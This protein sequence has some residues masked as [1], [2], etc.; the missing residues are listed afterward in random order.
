MVRE[1]LFSADHALILPDG[2]QL[3]GTVTQVVPAR[4]ISRSGQL[5]FVL[6]ELQVPSGAVQRIQASVQGIDAA[7][8]SDLQLDAEGGVHAV[9]PT[10]Y[11]LTGFEV[12]LAATPLSL[13]VRR[14]GFH[15]GSAQHNVDYPKTAIR[16]ALG[17]GLA[18]AIV[19]VLAHSRPVSAAFGYYGM[20]W[21]VYS[22]FLARGEDVVLPKNT[23]MDIRFGTYNGSVSAPPGN[24]FVSQVA[25]AD[26]TDF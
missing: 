17:M 3:T 4:R 11:A 9:P 19:T 23:L 5:R 1:P 6:L 21:R 15:P 7:S 8:Q 24:P 10:Y 2:A 26:K 22:H 25:K 16:G 18:G 13:S 12:F 20:G 14:N